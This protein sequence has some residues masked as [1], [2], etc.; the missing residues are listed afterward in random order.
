PARAT[1]KLVPIREGWM[2]AYTG[3]VLAKLKPRRTDEPVG[4]FGSTVGLFARKVL[5]WLLAATGRESTAIGGRNEDGSE[6]VWPARR[7]PTRTETTDGVTR[8]T[9]AVTCRSICSIRL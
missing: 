6:P 1:T 2:S 8:R 5:S 4:A 3:L 9:I 7:E